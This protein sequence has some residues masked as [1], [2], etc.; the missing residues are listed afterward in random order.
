MPGIKTPA[1][2]WLFMGGDISPATLAAMGEAW[3]DPF[4]AL[5]QFRTM[6]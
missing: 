5:R 6:L 1:L 2:Q 4:V 3:S